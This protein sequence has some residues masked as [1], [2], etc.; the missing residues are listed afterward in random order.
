MTAE[1]TAF[2][3]TLMHELLTD[4]ADLTINDSGQ[5]EDDLVSTL[6]GLREH[7][8]TLRELFPDDEACR[9]VRNVIDALHKL[10]EGLIEGHST[11]D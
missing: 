11:K 4:M 5:D 6:V 1:L 7:S 2:R 10:F 3:N 8:R 9:L